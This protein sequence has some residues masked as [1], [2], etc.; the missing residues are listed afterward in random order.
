M[1]NFNNTS[2][3]TFYYSRLHQVWLR[4]L[5]L[6]TAAQLCSD[7]RIEIFDGD[8]CA[9][10]FGLDEATTE[11]LQKTVNVVIHA[12][13]S[14]NLKHSLSRLA[15]TIVQ[16]TLNAADFALGCRSLDRFVYI[17]TAYANAY[18][19]YLEPSKI[20]FISERIHPLRN[21]GDSCLD[22]ESE[23]SYLQQH[24]TTPQYETSPFPFAYAYAKHLTERLLIN[25]FSMDKNDSPNMSSTS[26]SSA[27]SSSQASTLTN[28]ND[29]PTLASRL[30]IIRPSIIGPA[31]SSPS[32]GWQIATSAPV[33]GLLTFFIFTPATRLTF[34][35]FFPS[36]S[37]DALIDEVP[38]DIV[39]NRI[40]LHLSH[41]TSGIVH[42]NRQL[43]TCHNFG[44]YVRSAQKL[45]RLPWSCKILWDKDAASPKLC[46]VSK[47]YQV[48]GCTFQFED[49]QTQTLWD[50]KMS[51]KEKEMWPL[52]A[53][54]KYAMKKR[55]NNDGGG[56]NVEL[57]DLSSRE[58]GFRSLS[59][60]HF[61]RK[62]WPGWALS[63]LYGQR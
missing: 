34:Y 22:T 46:P 44:T 20:P 14:I 25:K 9:K 40:L 5:P 28:N 58:Q 57:L 55:R 62:K 26:L 41:S 47:L 30:L 48:S 52:F 32:P 21:E 4:T 17:S 7:S 63:M 38:V 51:E 23:W 27:S 35:S 54:E 53:V 50:C 60:M 42:A 8:V 13:S 10:N 18:M 24:G 29:D 33:T 39:T 43:S 56:K 2:A 37:L 11:E 16:G 15:P 19:H 12:A 49:A 3:N 59:E 45:R 6:Q 31:L 1:H 36:P 61:K